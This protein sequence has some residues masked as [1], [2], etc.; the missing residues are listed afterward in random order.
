M[1]SLF[2]QL[3]LL[4][5]SLSG[6]LYHYTLYL[7]KVRY[8]LTKLQVLASSFLKRTC[9][10]NTLDSRNANSMQMRHSQYLSFSQ[11]FTF[12]LKIPSHSPRFIYSL[13][14]PQIKC[15]HTSC[16]IECHLRELLHWTLSKRVVTLKSW[17]IELFSWDLLPRHSQPDQDPANPPILD[18]VSFFLAPCMLESR[19]SKE[20]CRPGNSAPLIFSCLVSTYPEYIRPSHPKGR[21]GLWNLSSLHFSLLSM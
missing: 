16:F 11:W 12:T 7:R 5:L 4:F 9:P 14:S 6:E 15:M 20:R 8:S 17:N 2:W 1:D 13:S 19:H 10:A 3:P 18:F 21:H